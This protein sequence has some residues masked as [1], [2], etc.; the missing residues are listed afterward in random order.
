MKE[1]I[2]KEESWV[3]WIVGES[4]IKPNPDTIDQ[5]A[6]R[7]LEKT[8]D[9]AVDAYTY[10]ESDPDKVWSKL[11][12]QMGADN[13]QVPRK[14]FSFLRY[15]AIFIA[16][17]ALGTLTLLL[18]RPQDK[19]LDKAIVAAPEMKIIQTVSK[20]SAYTTVVLPDGST[21]KIN[22]NST[23][24]YPAKFAGPN[25]IVKLSGE[26]YFDVIHDSSRPFIVEMSN[27]VVEDLGT[28]FNISAYPGKEKVEVNVVTGR[29]RL[30]DK[31]QK[32]TRIL[33]AGSSGKFMKRNGDIVVTNELTPN[34]L[35][36]ITKEL[37][38]HHTP[39]STVLEELEN[40][41]HV[42]IEVADPKIADISYTA[43]FEKS[44]IEDIVNVIAETHHLTVRKQADGFV[45]TSK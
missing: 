42:R 22:A 35:S 39:L 13:K 8:W 2:S 12:A 26:A 17:F 21:V 9:L 30:F 16:L 7:V 43:N 28:S 6:F 27:V 5:E 1:E 45:F 18:T 44:Q 14:Q 4:E 10:R 23:L 37:S 40:I 24:Q 41:Y 3:N 29:V 36:W 19:T 34:Y 38:F 25:R 15:A 33:S 20:P 32:S 31:D 11:G